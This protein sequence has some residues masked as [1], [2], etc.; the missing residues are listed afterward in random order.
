MAKSYKRK[1]LICTTAHEIC[2][3]GVFDENYVH[4]FGEK[5]LNIMKEKDADTATE[6]G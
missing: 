5:P 1:N 3:R 4:I 6:K 2:D